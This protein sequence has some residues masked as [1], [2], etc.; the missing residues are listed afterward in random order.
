MFQV[1]K[2][3]I[4][5]ECFLF[6]VFLLRWHQRLLSCPPG[7]NSIWDEWV[8]FFFRQRGGNTVE[9]CVH[10][11]KVWEK[12]KEFK[13]DQDEDQNDVILPLPR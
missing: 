4:D 13:F 1:E 6:I 9:T 12:E 11:A 2:I 5:E 3:K 8:S 10:V 7:L